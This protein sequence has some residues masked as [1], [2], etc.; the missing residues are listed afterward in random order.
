[1]IRI[2]KHT[3]LFLLGIFFFPIVFQSVHTVW[4]YSPTYNGEH[5]LYLHT[6]TNKYLHTNGKNVSEKEKICP[7]CTYQ[8]AINN[9]PTISFFNPVIPTFTCDYNEIVTQQYYKQ[10]ISDKTP[11]APPVF[12]S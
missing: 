4:H 8:F 11:R 7:I 1:M 9:L 10:V 12:I 5:T 3:A 6:I 2:R